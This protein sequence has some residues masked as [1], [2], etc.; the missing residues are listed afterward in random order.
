MRVLRDFIKIKEK[1]QDSDCY[2]ETSKL[3]KIFQSEISTSENESQG[4]PIEI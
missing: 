3:E 2:S 1:N 4:K